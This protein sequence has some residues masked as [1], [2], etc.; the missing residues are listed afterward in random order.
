MLFLTCNFFIAMGVGLLI[1]M[2]NVVKR[3]G[4]HT[5]LTDVSLEAGEHEIFG[6]LD[7]SGAAENL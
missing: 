3:F 1:K 2:N 5:V 7:P 6:L 4:V